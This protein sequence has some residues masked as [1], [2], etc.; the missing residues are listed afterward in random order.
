MFRITENTILLGEV[1]EIFEKEEKRLFVIFS[2]DCK[3]LKEMS[4]KDEI[5]KSYTLKTKQLSSLQIYRD[6]KNADASKTL[7]FQKE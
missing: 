2:Q 5:S 1:K 3:K 4:Y 7:T 6:N